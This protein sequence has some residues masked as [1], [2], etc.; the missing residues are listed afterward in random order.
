LGSARDSRAEKTKGRRRSGARRK[1]K[2]RG[3]GGEE[4]TGRATRGKLGL[5]SHFLAKFSEL[6]K[7]SPKW[8]KIYVFFWFSNQQIFTLKKIKPNFSVE[9]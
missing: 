4:A 7:T 2:E 3:R 9:F 5:T 1:G 6:A 8:L